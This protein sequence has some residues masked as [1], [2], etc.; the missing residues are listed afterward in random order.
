MIREFKYEINWPAR[1]HRPGHHRS[2]G[3]GSGFEFREHLSLAAD[4][5]PRRLDLHAS[6]SDPFGGFKVRSLRERRTIKVQ[7]LADLSASIRFGRKLATVADFSAS[8][9]H[10]AYRT[11]DAFGFMAAAAE[12]IE[13]LRVP[14][15]RSKSTAAW[16]D[17]RLHR[18]HCS[19]ESSIGLLDAAKQ[20]ER[21]HALV[22]LLS[23]FHFELHAIDTLLRSLSAHTVVPVVLWEPAEYAV[24][25]GTGLAAARDLESGAERT[26]WWRGSFSARARRA[27]AERRAALQ[28]LFR[29]HALRPLLLPAFDAD[30]V[31]QYFAGA[32]SWTDAAT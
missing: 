21:R 26:L 12:V 4:P 31:S 27:F 15:R 10:S 5:E 18:H 24:P 16:L 9:A 3:R 28:A 29:R 6:L 2:H 13:P 25:E 30:R 11:G 20:L 7:V 19:G 23:D 17:E 32:P 22:F 14:A 8:A 1:G